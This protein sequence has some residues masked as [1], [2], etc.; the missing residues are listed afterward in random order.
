MGGW[1]RMKRQVRDVATIAWIAAG[2]R[3]ALRVRG[4][5]EMRTFANWED[6]P[7]FDS[8]E[9]E[10]GFWSENRPALRLIS[11][12]GDDCVDCCGSQTRA[13]EDLR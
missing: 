3:P 1:L 2:H 9:A 4:R 11:G 8:E 6:V 12:R 10:A 5:F 7:I 13:P